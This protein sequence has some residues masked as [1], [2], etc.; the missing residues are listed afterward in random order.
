MLNLTPV[1]S[2][3][4]ISWHFLYKNRMNQYSYLIATEANQERSKNSWNTI[5]IREFYLQNHVKS[6]DFKKYSAKWVKHQKHCLYQNFLFV[7]AFSLSLYRQ[8]FL[9]TI[10]NAKIFRQNKRVT[11]SVTDAPCTLEET[12]WSLTE[13]QLILFWAPCI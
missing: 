11:D 9:Y 12:D 5:E 3:L 7:V 1:W 4:K 8:I 10:S 2:V 6:L 13:D